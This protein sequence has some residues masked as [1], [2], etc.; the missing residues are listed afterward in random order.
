MEAV[1]LCELSATAV[2][3]GFLILYYSDRKAPLYAK[4][5]VFLGVVCSM[6]CF[7]IL[8]IDIYESSLEGTTHLRNVQTAWSALYYVNFFLCWLVLPF[9]QEYEDS[10]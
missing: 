5:L 3:C 8:P 4:M 6:L 10:G 1:Y 7:A 9:A 2:L